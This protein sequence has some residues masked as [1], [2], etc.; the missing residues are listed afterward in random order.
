MLSRVAN[1]VYWLGRYRERVENTARLLDVNVRLNADAPIEM[2]NQWLPIIQT[3]GG[4]DAFLEEHS[5]MTEEEAI[6]FLAFDKKN[7]NSIFSCI[8]YSREIARSIRDT[9]T[10]EMWNE[11]NTTYLFIQ[12]S[13]RNPK[14]II[15]YDQLFTRVKRQC[16]LFTG[17]ADTCMSHNEAWYF[18]RM[19]SALERADMTTRILDL[20]Y[21]MLLPSLDYVGKPFDNLQWMSLLKSVDAFEMY[22]KNW[23]RIKPHN[24]VHFLIL[25]EMFPRSVS[26]CLKQ[27]EKALFKIDNFHETAPVNLSSVQVRKLKKLLD[28]TNGEE[29]IVK[30]LH[31]FIDQIQLNL[32]E[33]NKSVF[34]R[35]FALKPTGDVPVIE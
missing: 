16:Q 13:A 34:D 11:I 23:R 7:P 31:E 4:E 2:G 14:K 33:I 22:R 27:I 17:I 21:F 9:I 8:T 19:G 15:S 25:H 10:S 12:K 20:K 18:N 6:H 24:V 30:G 35:Y 26:F 28:N 32:A 3:I 5:K 1:S 29:I